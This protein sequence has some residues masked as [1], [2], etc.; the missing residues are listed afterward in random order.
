MDL[1]S[2]NILFHYKHPE[3]YGTLENPTV[4]V[5]EYNPLCGDRIQLDIKAE[6]G[7]IIDIG[8]SGSGC[9]IS[10]AASSMLTEKILGKTWQE[11]QEMTNEKVFEML[12]VPIS[13]ARVKCALL[14]LVAA[15][16]AAILGLKS[17]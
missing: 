7:K 1:Y 14:A 12:G 16:K 9:A 13:P 11:I 15:K 5:M 17:S 8:F 6:D 2:E 3:H 4:S 10:Q